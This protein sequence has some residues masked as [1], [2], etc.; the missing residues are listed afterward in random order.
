MATLPL[1]AGISYAE[2]AG[3][4]GAGMALLSNPY[5]AAAAAAAAAAAY[6]FSPTVRHKVNGFAGSQFDQLKNAS[7]L[8]NFFP[9]TEQDSGQS[10][11]HPLSSLMNVLGQNKA[12]AQP[13]QQN[14]QQ[15][16]NPYTMPQ[17]QGL[18]HNPY[19]GLNAIQYR[20]SNYAYP[21]PS[22]GNQNPMY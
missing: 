10:G 4:G 18:F 12:A 17:T 9:N 11:Q 6:G 2:G 15:Q 21:S 16:Q 19:Q 14:Q 7:L 22:Y 3:A 5:T 20:D 8:G 13:N 1:Q